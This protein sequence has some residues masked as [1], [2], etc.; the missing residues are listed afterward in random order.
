MKNEVNKYFL[1]Q[2]LN[3]C[4]VQM[5]EAEVKA[6]KQHLAETKPH[7]ADKVHAK[8]QD[9]SKFVLCRIL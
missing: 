3:G 1:N 6:I 9:D 2:L 7:L 4:N 8:K 5:Y